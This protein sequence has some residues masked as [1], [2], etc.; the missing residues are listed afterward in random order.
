[1]HQSS[2]EATMPRRNPPHLLRERT[3][4]GAV[5]W[6]VR[7][8]KGPRI[9]LREA[10]DTPAFWTEY[11]A[12]VEGKPPQRIAGAAIGTLEWGIDRYRASSAWAALAPA[13]R[14]QR[15]NIYRQVIE[16][17]GSKALS[18]INTR[19]I[20]EGRE[21]RAARPHGAN[22][23]VKSMRAFF[24]WAA[25]PKAGALV[26]ADP[27]AG[28]ALLGSQNPNGYHAWTDAEVARFEARWPLGSRERLAL[29]VLLYT[30]LR[31]G[32]AVRVGPPHL[33]DGIIHFP[34]TEKTGE[35]IT[36]PL[37][38]PL[39]VS[40]AATK[41]RGLTFIETS[42]GRPFRKASFGNWFRGAC[43]AAGVPGAAHGLRKAGATRAADNGASAHQ[44]MAIFG[45]TTMKQAEVYTRSADRKR[46]AMTGAMTML[47]R[48]SENETARTLVSGA[49][50]DGENPN[51]I[52]GRRV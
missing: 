41:P 32:D 48:Q 27:T 26:K 9:R 28:I 24:A 12:A 19:H 34:A 49:G 45:W 3:R 20:V 25:D 23:F 30:G 36:I 29:D 11:R 38:E 51:N 17:S 52:K 33:R 13:T 22:N 35:P 16:A 37:L 31:R 2:S 4:H 46:N 18:S 10:Y 5:V 44:L 21:R 7:V 43:K 8:G 47:P 40:I 50:R 15:E 39:R 1:M 42:Q 14:R 6:Y